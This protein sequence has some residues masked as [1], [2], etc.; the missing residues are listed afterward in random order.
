MQVI[1]RTHLFPK[2]SVTFCNIVHYIINRTYT[3]S[4]S[5][6]TPNHYAHILPQPVVTKLEAHNCLGCVCILEH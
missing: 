5:M 6:W 2:C 3:V 1:V 4:K